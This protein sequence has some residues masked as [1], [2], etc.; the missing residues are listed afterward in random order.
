MSKFKLIFEYFM[1]F[2]DFF[3]FSLVL[4]FVQMLICLFCF[5]YV[6]FRHNRHFW[7]KK[8]SCMLKKLPLR[9]KFFY[10]FFTLTFAL[11]NRVFINNKVS[12]FTVGFVL[13]FLLVLSK[14]YVPIILFYIIFWILII[15]SFVFA[16]LYQESSIFKNIIDNNLFGGDIVFAKDYFRFFWGNMQNGAKRLA[17]PASFTAIL[18]VLYRKCKSSEE[19][20]VNSE[21]NQQLQQAVSLSKNPPETP[22]EVVDLR[23][24]IR[25]TVIQDQTFIMKGETEV[26]ARVNEAVVK[27]GLYVKEILTP[28]GDV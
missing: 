8:C 21:T 4:E 7:Y 15:E 25:K 11:P 17:K 5:L 2:N 13:I 19:K 16:K 9:K 26:K 22:G 3:S 27:T 10:F 14:F 6:Y 1:S 20:Y 23:G 12:S 28:P 24:E 18:G